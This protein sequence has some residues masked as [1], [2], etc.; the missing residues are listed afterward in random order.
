L[1]PK[2]ETEV[3]GVPPILE[4]G[5][6]AAG[7]ARPPAADRLAHRRQVGGHAEPRL[8]A[9]VRD[10]ERHHLVEDEHDPQ[11]LRDR[12]EA[13]DVLLRGL[14]HP[15][16]ALD[17]LED[18]GRDA[19]AFALEDLL[20]AVGIVE[21]DLDELVDDAREHAGRRL[22]R[23]ADRRRAARDHVVGVTVVA[24]LRL[25]EPRP[26]RVRAR[27]AQRE[28]VRLRAGDEEADALDRR[29][30]LDEQRRHPVLEV[31]LGAAELGALLEL[32]DDCVPDPVVRVPVDDDPV[33][34][35]EVEV[36]VAVDVPDPRA[37]AAL[38]QD[39]VGELV[40][41][42]AAVAGRDQRPRALEQLERPPRPLAVA[43]LLTR[44]EGNALGCGGA[45][46]ARRGRHT[47]DNIR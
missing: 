1:P 40:P 24:A 12:A 6:A 23:D 5:G 26:A 32:L 13:L 21:R 47:C 3:T 25:R 27:E 22:G 35:A 10:R 42:A 11:P 17:G 46:C 16:R 28:Q 44:V 39:R 31:P 38:E 37:L 18:D 15:R 2:V 19:R 7:G 8:G 43:R 30:P 29:H 14:D 34:D 45:G 4:P 33:A 36:L 9:A 41:H 20:G